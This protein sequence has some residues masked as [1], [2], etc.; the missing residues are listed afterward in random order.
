[1][2]ARKKTRAQASPA[3]AER[4]RIHEATL[5]PGPSGFVL[6]GVEITLDE[7]ITRRKTGR[8]VVVCGS[9]TKANSRLAREI[10]AAVGPYKQEPPHKDSGPHALPHF[11]P[12]PRPLAGHT[13]YETDNPLRKA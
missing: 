10:E 12:N 9:E 7:A 3:P 4:P 11:Q 2:A 8:D 5:E 13:F 1:M 6:R